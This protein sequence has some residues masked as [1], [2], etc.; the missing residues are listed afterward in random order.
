MEV[1]YG[2]YVRMAKQDG[3]YVMGEDDRM[4]LEHRVPGV[5][6]KRTF[7]G[8]NSVAVM[9]FTPEYSLGS[10]GVRDLLYELSGLDVKGIVIDLTSDGLDARVKKH[11]VPRVEAA[12]TDK[13]VN[14]VYAGVGER[15]IDKD[16]WL[17]LKELMNSTVEQ[18]VESLIQQPVQ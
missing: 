12:C 16:Y 5:V 6:V 17:V 15:D 4:P 8:E 3:F 2:G 10:E 13:T 14:R 11:V 9:E 18:A 1:D 7:E